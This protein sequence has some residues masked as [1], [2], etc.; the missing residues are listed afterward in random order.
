METILT[1][2]Q[3]SF[4]HLVETVRALD[5]I[6]VEGDEQTVRLGD[7]MIRDI[8]DPHALAGV[9]RRVDIFPGRSALIRLVGVALAEQSDEWTEGR[10][11][12][13]LELLA[14]TEFASFPSTPTLTQRANRD[15]P[16]TD[17]LK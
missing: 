6:S 4:I 2:D 8:S 10:R 12:M 15:N 3:E 9:Y 13:S 17:R 16:A 14:K 7:Q 1:L 5:Y 11:P